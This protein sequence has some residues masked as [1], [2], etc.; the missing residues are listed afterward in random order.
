VGTYP[1]GQSGQTIGFSGG[2]GIVIWRETV[3]DG[4]GTCAAC[5]ITQE[6]SDYIY[7]FLASD[8]FTPPTGVHP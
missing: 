6:G 4:V 7:T 5:T 8:T 1:Y 2:G 3:S